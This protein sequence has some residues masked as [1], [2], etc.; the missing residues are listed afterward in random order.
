M[1]LCSVLLIIIYQLFIFVQPIQDSSAAL[2]SVKRFLVVCAE[3]KNRMKLWGFTWKV[4]VKV[5]LKENKIVIIVKTF[6]QGVILNVTKGEF[7]W[8]P[9]PNSPF[10]TLVRCKYIRFGKR[11][12]P[13]RRSKQGTCFRE[14]PSN[15]PAS[16]SLHWI[17]EFLLGSGKTLIPKR[18][19]RYEPA[20]ENS[21]LS[22]QH[23]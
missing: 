2:G 23:L 8:F 16:S 18:R 22:F 9:F 15:I 5:S 17:Y 19:C 21:H 12:G 6:Y 7:E 3:E 4:T 10:I 20:W 1:D 13:K 14:H 11:L